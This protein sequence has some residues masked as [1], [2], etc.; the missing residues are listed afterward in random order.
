MSTHAAAF[1]RNDAIRQGWKQALAHARTVMGVVAIGWLVGFVEQMVRGAPGAYSVGSRLALLL[2]QGIQIA[3]TL[4]AISLFL[5]IHDGQ[6]PRIRDML[7]ALPL[8]FPFLL[9]QIVYGLIV[10]GGLLLLLVP[11]VIWAIRFGFFGFFMVDR[12]LDP[13]AALRASW[14]LTQGHARE[15]FWFA[16]VVLGI[17]LVGAIA[18]GVGLLITIPTTAIAAARVYRAL[19]AAQDQDATATAHALVSLPHA[20]S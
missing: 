8:Y 17:N 10:A 19:V 1:D 5:R 3:V 18:L 20:T 11:G 9:A 14:R 16:L 15:L 12:R 13:I 4:G 2:L 7:D 6:S